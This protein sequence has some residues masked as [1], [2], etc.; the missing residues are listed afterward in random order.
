MFTVTSVLELR[1]SAVSQYRACGQWQ[2]TDTCFIVRKY[3]L[4][5]SLA[6]RL[7]VLVKSLKTAS[8]TLI[9]TTCWEKVVFPKPQQT[10]TIQLYLISDFHL[11]H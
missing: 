6:S 8:E 9:H 4:R 3:R 10:N 1:I 2:L 5:S 7:V 11:Q